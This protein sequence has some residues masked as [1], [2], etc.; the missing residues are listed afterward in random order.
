MPDLIIQDKKGNLMYSGKEG[1]KD[2]VKMIP[3][4][5]VLLILV[6]VLLVV[7]TKFKWIH[8]SQIPMWCSVYCN[9]F[10][11]SRVLLV[12]GEGGIGTPIDLKNEIMNY[13]YYTI[14]EGPANVNM[15]SIG[16]L[17]NYEVVILEG[18]KNITK[19]QADAI[20]MYLE[21]GGNM[22]W[23]GDAGTGYYL[24]EED[25]ALAKMRNQS[26]PWYYERLVRSINRTIGFGDLSNYLLVSY[27]E[28]KHPSKEI[29]F[30][31]INRDHMIMK[32]IDT[33]FTIPAVPFA[34]VRPVSAGTNVLAYLR[35]DG[36]DYPAIVETKYVGRIVYL[37]FPIEQIIS[38]TFTPGREGGK[39]K[40]LLINIMDYLVTC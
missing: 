28:T 31:T 14:V 15:L 9:L 23:I 29:L 16:Y 5:I 18:V 25:L 26:E 17:K 3:H 39:G 24:S 2:F 35:I 30:K 8:C 11:R 20:K 13:R 38:K 1:Q 22:L 27:L 37:A 33:E 10:G 7:L 40:Y 12:T 21:Q 32:G 19:S 6:L 36:K 34:V 4:V